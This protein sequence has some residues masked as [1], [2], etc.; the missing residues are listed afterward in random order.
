MRLVALRYK[1]AEPF[2]FFCHWPAR[3]TLTDC[4]LVLQATIILLSVCGH[5][6]WNA[7]PYHRIFA[8]STHATHS[9][10][11]SNHIY[12]AKL[13]TLALCK[14]GFIVWCFILFLSCNACCF[15]LSA[16]KSVKYV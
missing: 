10:D 15:C 16:D 1:S 13:L 12:L 4:D 11:Q 3:S 14:C 9:D 8:Q 7:S 5:A 2:Y 6:I